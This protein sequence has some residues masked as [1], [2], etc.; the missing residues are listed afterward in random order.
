MKKNKVFIVLALVFIL[1]LAVPVSIMGLREIAEDSGL[2]GKMKV[3]GV[4]YSAINRS[5]DFSVSRIVDRK[6]GTGSY[7]PVQ[8]D[9]N[10]YI[11]GEDRTV[12]R[13]SGAYIDL[14]IYRTQKTEYEKHLLNFI[15][16]ENEL[17]RITLSRMGNPAYDDFY[18]TVSVYEGEVI[19]KEL[20]E[21][22]TK[23]VEFR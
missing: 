7:I 19:F 4:F 5:L 20:W 14:N 18:V 13:P 15:V 8:L 16:S 11:V 6:N 3:E 17:N 1:Q 2:Q 23:L 21:G 22:E 9:E 10:G 12:V